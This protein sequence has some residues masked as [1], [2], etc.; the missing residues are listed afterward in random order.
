MAIDL[1]PQ[2]LARL[3]TDLQDPAKFR[4][5]ANDPRAFVQD[6]GIT[7]DQTMAD[8]VKRALTGVN[9]IAD[10]KASAQPPPKA[11]IA[12]AVALPVFAGAETVIGAAAI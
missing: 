11:F 12:V 7:I 1:D 5:F 10:L 9:S 4:R 3:N 8:Q 6:F 2:E